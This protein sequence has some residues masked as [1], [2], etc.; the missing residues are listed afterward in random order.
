MVCLRDAPNDTK[1]T[2]IAHGPE[3]IRIF[4]NIRGAPRPLE[5]TIFALFLNK[6]G[7]GLGNAISGEMKMFQRRK[8]S[9]EENAH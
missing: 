5:A 9:N 4:C 3:W 8:A 7:L 2:E 6:A 1:E